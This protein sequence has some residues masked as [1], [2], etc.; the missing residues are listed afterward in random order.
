MVPRA[1]LVHIHAKNGKSDEA[2]ALLTSDMDMLNVLASK[3]GRPCLDSLPRH[4]AGRGAGPEG[5]PQEPTAAP[6][7]RGR[8]LGRALSAL[9]HRHLRQP[10]GRD[11]LRLRGRHAA[12]ASSA[13]IVALLGA[14]LFAY[15]YRSRRPA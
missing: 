3:L 15:S 2:E 5:P 14:M 9:R 11:R 7:Q 12:T 10:R 8:H 13:A 4:G 6:F 1:L